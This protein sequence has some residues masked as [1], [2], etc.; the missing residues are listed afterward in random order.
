[1]S[2]AGQPLPPDQTRPRS[3]W[4]YV[5][6]ISLLI[7]ALSFLTYGKNEIIIC[8]Q[9]NNIYTVDADNPRVQ[10]ISI[11]G[12]KILD[13]GSYESLVAPTIFWPQRVYDLHPDSILLP[14]FADAHAHILENG[15]MKQLPLS[16]AKSPRD[17]ISR[18]RNYVLSHPDI[19]RNRTRWIQGMGWD[20]TKWPNKQ[21]P[22]A[23]ELDADPVLAGRPIALRRVDGH[24]VWVSQAVLDLA[25]EL[26]DVE[27]GLII[28]DGDGN[29]TGVFVD[30]AM[31]LIPFPETTDPELE[32]FFETTMKEALKYGLTSIHDAAALPSYIQFFKRKAEEGNLPLRLYLMGNVPK[33]DGYWGDKLPRLINYG[34]HGRLNLRSVKLFSDGAL[35]SWGAALL[36]PYTDRSDTTGLLLIDEQKLQER[37]RQFYSNNWQVNI[38]CIGDRANHIVLNIFERIHEEAEEHGTSITQWRPRIEH[39]QIMTQADLKRIGRLGVIASVQPT[40]ATS[41]MWYAETRLGPTRIR[42]AYAYQTLLRNSPVGVLPLGSDFPVEGV[43]PLL[44]FYAA[45]TR[46][47]AKGDSPQGPGGWYPDE[48]LSRFQALKGMTLDAA[49]ASFSEKTHGSLSAGKAAD[50][51]ILDRNIMDEKSDPGEI[52]KAKVLTTVIDG[53]IV[54]GEL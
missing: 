16:D 44:G 25:G 20:Q 54:Y 8:S 24:A 46:L 19:H 49:Y 6:G 30:N 27:G 51:V 35:G 34:K 48:R 12:N 21:F 42:G 39:A 10:C 40:H 5:L 41:D 1:M 7:T 37:V 47:S 17:V 9:S 43:N 2:K 18:V 26:R 53:K 38:H 23:A 28:R 15:F 50:F 32:L 14:G 3:L 36:Q 4:T 11:R 29:P 45:V 31:S 33:D 52:L 22:T 13:I